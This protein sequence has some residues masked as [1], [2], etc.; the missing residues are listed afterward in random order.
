ME[1]AV[2]CRGPIHFVK[3]KIKGTAQALRQGGDAHRCAT[4][5][6][7]VCGDALILLDVAVQ[8]A[9]APHQIST[10][11]VKGHG[12]SQHKKEKWAFDPCRAHHSRETRGYPRAPTWKVYIPRNASGLAVSKSCQQSR[13]VSAAAAG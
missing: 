6:R 12:G 4:L 7:S 1:D 3:A 10:M 2:A 11:R 8:C 9:E 5:I 13:S